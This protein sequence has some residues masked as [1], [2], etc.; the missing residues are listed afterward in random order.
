MMVALR[1]VPHEKKTVVD[2]DTIF[3]CEGKVLPALK[4]SNEWTYLEVPFTPEGKCKIDATERIRDA[5]QKLARA[6]FKPQQCLFAL[7]TMVIPGLYHKLELGNT[8]LGM[9]RKCDRLLCCPASAAIFESMGQAIRRRRPTDDQR[10]SAE[11]AGA[12]S[13]R[14]ARI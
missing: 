9:L 12:E 13:L 14:D 6:P 11:A 8:T 10:A 3:L 1:N 7:R 2:K 4:R 5:I